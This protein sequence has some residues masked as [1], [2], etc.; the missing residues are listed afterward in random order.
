VAL[1]PNGRLL[2]IGATDN[3]ARLFDL[4]D[5][6]QTASVRHFRRVRAVAF[7]GDNRVL[8][9]GTDI[10]TC[11]IVDVA[12]GVITS[13]CGSDAD[14]AIEEITVN[15]DGTR[16][17]TVNE[18]HRVRLLDLRRGKPIAVPTRGAP[19]SS[20]LL[21]RDGRRLATNVGVFDAA[22]GHSIAR[23]T[24]SPGQSAV[25]FSRDERQVAV[26]SSDGSL[27]LFDAD[28]G[29][30]QARITVGGNVG[31]V[32]FDE[33][34]NLIAAASQ[35]TSRAEVVVS[36]HLVHSEDVVADVCGRLTRNLTIE[37]W[38]RH[39]GTELPYRKT[40]PNLK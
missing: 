40:C 7:S 24:A 26:G 31:A 33:R 9:T 27:R 36:R 20:V 34:G 38:Q 19:A 6:A 25:A 13:S 14:G 35:V 16:I 18:H 32:R 5:R 30:E 22:T 1:S 4:A 17:A 29:T 2:A 23:F 21:S 12:S 15:Q 28:T 37:E 11:Q 8:V 10:G 3:T 39:V